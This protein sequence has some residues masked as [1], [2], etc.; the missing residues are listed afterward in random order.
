MLGP[1]PNRNR[2]RDKDALAASRRA[3]ALMRRASLREGEAPLDRPIRFGTTMRNCLSHKV[4]LARGWVETDGDDWDVFYADVGWIH[5]NMPYA[6]AVSGGLR[7]N[8]RQRVNHF[9]NHIELTRK[10][11]MA[12]NMKRMKRALEKEGRAKEAQELDFF[13]TTYHMPSECSLFVRNWKESR[14]Q[15]EMQ[16]WIMKPIGRAQ[17]KGIFLVSKLSQIEAWMKERGQEKT[18]NCCYEDFVCQRYMCNPYLVG[19]RQFD[20]RL[21]ALCLSYIPLKVY[22]YRDGFARFSS[23]RFSMQKEDLGNSYVHLTNHAIQKQDQSYDPRMTDL[24][25]PLRNLRLHVAAT[26]GPEV[27]DQLFLEIERL[28]VH[29]LKAVQQTIINDKNC[30]EMYGYDVM[31]DADLKPWLI[32]VNASPSMSSDN[33]TDRALKEGLLHDTFTA[34]DIEGRFGGAPPLRVGGYDLVHDETGSV[35]RDPLSC[36]SSNLGTRND[37]KAQ[38]KTIFKKQPNPA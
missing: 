17:G 35:K 21:Y 2:E 5:E 24:K 20:L 34:V 6:G 32:E 28:V 19:G 8:D 27:A 13:M 9:P 12:K 3:A 18:D 25:W 11:L 16:V 38:L 15:G 36:I 31:I 7:L 4:M 23:T 1:P 26:H 22:L 33:D 37:R 29:S 14:A 30:Y 10:D